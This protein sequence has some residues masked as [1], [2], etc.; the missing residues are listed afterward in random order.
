[1]IRTYR[2]K[3]SWAER[4]VLLRCRVHRPRTRPPR[5]V[6]LGPHIDSFSSAGL[7]SPF[8]LRLAFTEKRHYALTEVFRIAEDPL[9][10]ALEIELPG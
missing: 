1:M 2:C 3:S 4:L 7:L 6:S 9:G 10:V 5:L 8:E